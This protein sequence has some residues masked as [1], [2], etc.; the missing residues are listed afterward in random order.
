MRVDL[1]PEELE[2]EPSRLVRPPRV[3]AS[4][5]VLECRSH[6]T[7]RMGNSTLVFGRV[8]LAA[9]HRE[10]LVD[11]RPNAERLRP[12]PRRRYIAAPL[13]SMTANPSRCR[14]RM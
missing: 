14:A 7:L 10:Y 8:F 6:T 12:L 11:G 2:R 3:A 13:L 1:D 5:V 4:P 9:V